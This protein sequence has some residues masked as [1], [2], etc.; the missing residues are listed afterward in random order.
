MRFVD[1]EIRQR[2][3]NLM[4]RSA[5]S[6]GMTSG[7]DRG[8]SAAPVKLGRIEL[9]CGSPFASS[10]IWRTHLIGPVTTNA[11]LTI[12]EIEQHIAGILG[13]SN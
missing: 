13:L 3:D 4:Q 5:M 8:I 9:H 12:A 2:L 11:A 7:C 6:R 10:G 1:V